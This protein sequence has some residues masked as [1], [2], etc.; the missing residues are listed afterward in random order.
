MA[1]SS[2]SRG[3]DSLYISCKR[4]RINLAWTERMEV[5]DLLKSQ[6]QGQEKNKTQLE[7]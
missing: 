2:A 4:R 7:W 6:S 5:N 1:E 3:A